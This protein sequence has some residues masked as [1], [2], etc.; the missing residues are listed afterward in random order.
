[1][2]KRGIVLIGQSNGFAGYCEDRR[3][4]YSH[5]NLWQ[6]K[7]NGTYEQAPIQRLD[8][9]S[10]GDANRVFVSY[11]YFMIRDYLIP[12]NPGVDY[13]ILPQS[14]GGT[15]FSLYWHAPNAAL[16]PSV[17]VPDDP[18]NLVNQ[19]PLGGYYL[20][21]T[22]T[23]M[24]AFLAME[25]GN[26]IDAVILQNGEQETGDQGTN[27]GYYHA[28]F[29]LTNQQAYTRYVTEMMTD[30]V[31]RVPAAA[32]GGVRSWPFFIG[33]PP[34][35][36]AYGPGVI[37]PAADGGDHSGAQ[38][39]PFMDAIAAMPTVVTNCAYL[40]SLNPV[41]VY[42]HDGVKTD[43][44]DNFHPNPVNGL[45]EPG[46]D[47]LP[48]VIMDANNYWLHTS[49]AG[50]HTMAHRFFVAYMKQKGFGTVISTLWTGGLVVPEAPS[51][52]L[53][54][55]SDTGSSSTDNITSDSTPD[56][57]VTFITPVAAGDIVRLRDGVVELVAH[58]ITAGEIG[59]LSF[60]LGLGPLP[61]GAHSLTA[62]HERG[63]NLSPY[64]AVLTFTV[65]S[66]PPVITTPATASVNEGVVL[67][68]PLTAT[69]ASAVT[70]T[71]TSD[72]T[73]SFEISG[74]TLR[75]TGNGTK[76]Y[77]GTGD[78]YACEVTVTDAAGNAAARS[79]T[80]SVL[81]VTVAARAFSAEG[82]SITGGVGTREWSANGVS[83][84][85]S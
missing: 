48:D 17:G 79:I 40:N 83:F 77:T 70:W 57:A 9:Q 24:N 38:Y 6:F 63:T 71:E 19:Y 60:A 39:I 51:L 22:I 33:Q 50:H 32:P 82:I 74:T 43:G 84:V 14:V 44:N 31:S 23:Q 7:Q 76:T 58:V 16:N 78:N 66:T 20:E 80:V 2:A 3:D 18:A 12:R 61:E 67:A 75:W 21:R 54:A 30:L 37:G 13:C 72:I 34:P 15:G 62:R 4:Q 73:N 29:S 49:Q 41:R 8:F 64:G 81:D 52:D 26:T 85:E 47:G 27:I 5:P 25:A 10:G 68:I 45:P 55:G 1:M 56:I 46:G 69:D 53:V 35:E 42:C 28:S 36:L 59:S 11:V 65:D